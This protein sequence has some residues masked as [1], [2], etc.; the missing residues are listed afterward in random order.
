MKSSKGFT[1][2]EL[3]IVIIVLGILATRAIPKFINIQNDAKTSVLNGVKGAMLNAI[4]ISYSK[5]AIDGLENKK[6]VY[7]TA[8]SGS[9]NLRL[10][11]WC[12]NC[13]FQY[14]YPMQSYMNNWNSMLGNVST[15]HS[16][17]INNDDVVMFY[18]NAKYKE[19]TTIITLASN[20]ALPKDLKIL[21][22][23]TAGNCYIEYKYSGIKGERPTVELFECK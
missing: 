3:I 18:R 7:S 21:K 13:Q 1:L 9:D 17:Y 22:E 11:S 6:Q 5:L 20:I 16:E 19:T 23:S 14:G 12:S 8:L 2:I 15:L 4:D 10:E